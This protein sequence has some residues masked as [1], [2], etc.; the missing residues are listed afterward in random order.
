MTER[1]EHKIQDHQKIDNEFL[2]QRII[3]TNSNVHRYLN[4]APS[5][6]PTSQNVS[7]PAKR[8]PLEYSQLPM[9]VHAFPKPRSASASK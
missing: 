2:Y 7:S 4:L 9:I 6:T 8:S 1:Y 3:Q 5:L